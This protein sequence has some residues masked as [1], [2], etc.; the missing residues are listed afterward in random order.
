[1]N[2][3]GI[4]LSIYEQLGYLLVGYAA[5]L[6]LGLDTHLVGSSLPILQSLGTVPGLIIAYILGNVIQAVANL[7]IEEK[8]NEFSET[9]A[10][11]L[12]KAAAYFRVPKG[13]RSLVFKLCHLFVLEKQRSGQTATFNAMYG[14]YRGWLV[15][16]ATQ[17]VV[18]VVFLISEPT[19]PGLTML[20]LI[21]SAAAT[22]LL[23]QR[24]NRFSSYFR[25]KVILGFV[26]LQKV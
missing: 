14:M 3:A 2:G 21:G 20:C 19:P 12:D 9:E 17:L 25:E 23:K 10:E 4:Q 15:V 24:V 13:D 18:L 26:V 5:L 16:A 8:K 6:V 22:S 1:M 7:F 11:L